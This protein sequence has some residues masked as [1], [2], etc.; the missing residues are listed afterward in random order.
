MTEAIT[1]NAEQEAAVRRGASERLSAVTGGAGTGKTT[2][3]KGIAGAVKSPVLCAPTGKAAAR[4]R[5]ATE[6][7]ASTIHS[8]LKFTGD[9]FMCRSLAGTN[10]IIDESSMVDSWLMAAIVRRKPDSIVLVGDSAQLFPVGAGA[11]FHDLINYR[12]EIVTELKTCY[13]NKEAIFRAATK[14]RAG[15]MPEREEQTGGER[16]QVRHT[17]SAERTQNLILSWV[18]S[19]ALDFTQDI[20]ICA[21]NGEKGDPQ[22]GTV[23]GLN[24]AVSQIV[25]PRNKNQKWKVGDRVIC[26]KNFPDQDIWNGTTG[27]IKAIDSEKEIWVTTDIPTLSENGGYSSETL[28]NKEMVR[29]LQLAYALTVHKS[30]GS[31]YRNVIFCCFRRDS[32]M[33]LNRSLI[34]TAITRAK[35]SC[36]VIGDSRAFAEGIRIESKRNTV[37]QQLA[38]RHDA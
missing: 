29:E 5:E 38:R 15:L 13:R 32:Y 27:T 14:I 10:L 26:L 16:W 12:P 24:R 6:M 37:I 1:F 8:L 35:K 30:Q 20:I 34:Y 31:Q 4:L 22:P 21:R 25:N 36:V 19:G 2:V 7:P 3:V 28:F 9:D 18:K 23:H 33:M 11:P 17:G